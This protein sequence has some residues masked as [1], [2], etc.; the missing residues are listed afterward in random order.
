V[1]TPLQFTEDALGS[2]FSLEML[3]GALDPLLTDG[4]LER[5]ALD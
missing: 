1:S 3:D 2:H 4:D 5:L